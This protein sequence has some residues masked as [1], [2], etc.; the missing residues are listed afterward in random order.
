MRPVFILNGP[1]LN[2]LGTREPEIYGAATLQDIALSCQQTADALGLSIDF[3]QTNHE[4]ELIA[5]VQEAADSA[6]AVILNA[7]AYTHTSIALH[8]ALKLLP[9]PLIEVHLSNIYQREA[10]RHHSYVSPLATAVLCGFG[11]RGYTLALV[12]LKQGLSNEKAS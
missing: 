8:D 1:N 5:W 7:A 9:C 12:A 2:R 11:A 10:F 6:G 4:G 3:R